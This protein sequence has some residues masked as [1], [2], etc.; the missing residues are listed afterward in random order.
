MRV[1]ARDAIFGVFCRRFG[2]PLIDGG[3]VR[4]PR[5]IGMSNAMDMI[6]TGRGVSGD[7]ALRMGLANRLVE[8]GEALAAAKVLASQIA[9][10][11]PRCM[12]SDRMSAHEAWTMPLEDA[13]RNEYRHGIATIQ[14]GETREGAARFASGSGRH[15]KF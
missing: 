4:L 12:R 8:R 13:I 6:L 11:P 9:A 15:G 1:A 10:F 2:V 5:L 14:S 3:T 7:E